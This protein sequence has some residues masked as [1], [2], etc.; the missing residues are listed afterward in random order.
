LCSIGRY[1]AISISGTAAGFSSGI[2]NWALLGKSASVSGGTI[3]I[4]QALD[5]LSRGGICI[6]HSFGRIL[7][8]V[9]IA[10]AGDNA[11]AIGTYASCGAIAIAAAS[12]EAGVLLQWIFEAGVL[13]FIA[14]DIAQGAVCI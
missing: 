9:G 8:A 4:G 10:G 11:L 14:A 5:T 1:W 3:C 12:L 2:A 13:F 7:I 6:A